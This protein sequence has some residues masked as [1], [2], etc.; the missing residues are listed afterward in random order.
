MHTYDDHFYRAQSSGSLRSAQIVVPFL[1]NTIPCRSV[2]DLGCG[3]GTWLS[4]FVS[5]GITDIMGIDGPYVERKN[6]LIPSSCFMAGDL[7]NPP[8]VD[9]VFDLAICLEVAEHIPSGAADRL[10]DKLVALSGFILFSAAI[11]FQGGENHINEQWPNYWIDKFAQH[12]YVPLDLLRDKFWDNE[13]IEF[14]YRQNL[15]L[16]VR[17]DLLS[18]V[19][20]V[21]QPAWTTPKAVVHPDQYLQA[22]RRITELEVDLL[23]K[24]EVIHNL[25]DRIEQLKDPSQQSAWTAFIFFIN[26]LLGRS[27]NASSSRQN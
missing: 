27:N 6:L 24:T 8:A 14:W 3:L 1:L 26:A 23:G 4:A 15:L 20:Q 13:A 21:P 19:Q 7:T 2:V 10:V 16:F 5:N 9:R 12:D 11:P 25:R 17:R 22:C 18:Q